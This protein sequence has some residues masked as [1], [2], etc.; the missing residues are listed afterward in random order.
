M[1]KSDGIMSLYRAKDKYHED[2]SC[3]K[4]FCEKNT[5]GSAGTVWCRDL[6]ESVLT[7]VEEESGGF[8]YLF[9]TYL[10]EHKFRLLVPA[11]S[12][13]LHFGAFSSRNKRQLT[14]SN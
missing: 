9:S 3:D 2:I 8:D 14:K 10:T 4:K 1:D 6:L 5:V 11:E 13:A 12:A 7:L